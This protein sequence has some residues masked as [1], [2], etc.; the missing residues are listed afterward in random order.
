MLGNIGAP[1]GCGDVMDSLFG[2]VEPEL[3]NDGDGQHGDLDV[4]TVRW[5]LSYILR[6]TD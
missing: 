3:A 4:A 5:I 6:M 2:D 1:L